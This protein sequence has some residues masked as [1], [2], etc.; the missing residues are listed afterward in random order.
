M[1][2]AKPAP[3]C[4]PH[5]RQAL[6]LAEE[7]LEKSPDDPELQERRDEAY[8]EWLI[9]PDG[10]KHLEEQ[11]AS[12]TDP[13]RA[14]D[15]RA[16]AEAQKAL[17]KERLDQY[18]ATKNPLTPEEKRKARLQQFN[19]ELEEGVEGLKTDKGWN[20]YLDKMSKFHRYSWNNQIL[21][22]LQRPNA[23]L[24]AGFNRWK[25]VDRNVKKGEKGITI[26][27]PKTATVPVLDKNGKEVLGENG[28]PQRRKVIRGFTTATVFDV[29]Q[30][31]GEPINTYARPL[32]SE[33]PPGF[34]NDL[35][36]AI[37]AEGYTVRE[38]ELPGAADGY[39][40]N[41][42]GVK[43]VV[44]RS[45]LPEGEKVKVLAHELGHI[46]MG[47]LSEGRRGQYH[48]GH[49]GQRGAM[50]VE[51]EGYAYVLC[52]ANGMDISDAQAGT[53]GYIAGWSRAQDGASADTKTVKA[54]AEAVAKAVGKTL[55]EYS[56]ANVESDPLVDA[57][58]QERPKRAPAKRKAAGASSRKK[59]T[60]SPAS[61]SKKGRAPVGAG[62]N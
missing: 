59:R 38:E 61:T 7:Q 39:T 20:E 24:V 60:T 31:E 15:L 54:G 25:D 18:E 16:S 11:A 48:T 5:A 42:S 51:A 40:R 49:G 3:R 10:I 45:S 41:H 47:H 13:Q 62:V 58:R 8:N 52:R 29:S 9:T 32:T 57:P 50:E 46:K 17:R 12:E 26:L 2:Y 55:G 1:C 56:W 37:T 23:S 22:A 6:Q 44:V 4:S 43:E 53:T 33:P 36:S 34:R 30:T 28:K 19:E 35:T 27:A 21:I 14:S